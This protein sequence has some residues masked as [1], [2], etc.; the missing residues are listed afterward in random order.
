[1]GTL[2]KG[3]QIPTPPKTHYDWVPKECQ[4][5]GSTSRTNFSFPQDHLPDQSDEPEHYALTS[6]LESTLAL[7]R[8]M[9]T[10]NSGCELA[11]TS[12]VAWF[13]QRKTVGA[14]VSSPSLAPPLE[15]LDEILDPKSYKNSG[16]CCECSEWRVS[17]TGRW[18]WD[19][20]KN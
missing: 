1:M 16:W 5:Y 9:R 15:A 19:Y 2:V 4:K 20:Y 7:P 11:S 12:L 10:R 6:R 14:A 3:L 8:K 18:M 17:V 13:A